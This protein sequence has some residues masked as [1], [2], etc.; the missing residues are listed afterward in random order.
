MKKMGNLE[1]AAH[2]F[3][4]AG[5]ILFSL[6]ELGSSLMCIFKRIQSDRTCVKRICGILWVIP[7]YCL[8]R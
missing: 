8:K 2:A 4:T 3:K 7:I 5:I 1:E 6:E